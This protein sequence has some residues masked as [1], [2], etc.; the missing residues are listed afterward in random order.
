M[1]L[2]G[3]GPQALEGRPWPKAEEAPVLLLSYN[4]LLAALAVVHW[5]QHSWVSLVGL[6]PQA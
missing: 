1:T 6:G 4:L 3:L 5:A 2:L